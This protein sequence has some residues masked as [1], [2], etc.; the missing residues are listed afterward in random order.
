[1]IHFEEPHLKAQMQNR[2]VLGFSKI[3][4]ELRAGNEA[5]A[6]FSVSLMFFLS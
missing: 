3:V 4:L 1:M 5:A 2:V 6:L